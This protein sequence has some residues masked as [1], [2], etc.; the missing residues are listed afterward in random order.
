MARLGQAV[1]DVE[2]GA[3]RLEGVAAVTGGIGEVR[4]P[5][6]GPRQAVV[7]EHGVDLMRNGGSKSP[8]EVAGDAV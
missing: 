3:G 5:G 4:A 8:E 1:L 6:S 2:I 7:G